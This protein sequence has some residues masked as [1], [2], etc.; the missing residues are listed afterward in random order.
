MVNSFQNVIHKDSI[1]DLNS[2]GLKNEPCLIFCQFAALDMVGV[3]G[4]ANL[5]L[6]IQTAG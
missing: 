2:V 1:S 5:Q 3:V 4:H 6:M